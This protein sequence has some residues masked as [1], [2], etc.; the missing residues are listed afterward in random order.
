VGGDVD[1]WQ[2]GQILYGGFQQN[3]SQ[4]V[5][6]VTKSQTRHKKCLQVPRTFSSSHRPHWSV[7]MARAF[8]GAPPENEIDYREI[9][10][11]FHIVNGDNNTWNT[12]ERLQEA[13]GFYACY[14]A[15]AP[16]MAEFFQGEIGTNSGNVTPVN[17]T[18][19]VNEDIDTEL[20]LQTTDPMFM[21]EQVFFALQTCIAQPE[22]PLDPVQ[23]ELNW[24]RQWFDYDP[25]FPE[26]VRP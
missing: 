4:K 1:Q 21:Y 12:I 25:F 10:R 6:P 18:R 3:P 11:I 22:I 17:G 19:P 26:I 13:E 5:K 8:T 20:I 14:E 9:A 16:E 23:N 24:E 7:P 15:F 2:I